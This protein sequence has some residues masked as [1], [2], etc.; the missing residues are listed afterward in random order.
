MYDPVTFMR[1]ALLAVAVAIVGAAYPSYRAVRLTRWRRCAMSD[2]EPLI[3][4]TGV[5]RAFED[6]RIPALR[7]ASLTVGRGEY[8]A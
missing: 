5:E 2:P 7:G 6:G 1:A 3:V 4:V 8:V